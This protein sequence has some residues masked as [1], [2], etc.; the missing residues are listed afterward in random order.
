MG[1]KARIPHPSIIGVAAPEEV[2]AMLNTF[3]DINTLV[4][5][6]KKRVEETP[7]LIKKA[8]GLTNKRITKPNKGYVEA[9]DIPKKGSMHQVKDVPY[10]ER[11]AQFPF[12][13]QDMALM[14][15][16]EDM[17]TKNYNR[18]RE[19]KKGEKIKWAGIYAENLRTQAAASLA[20]G[21]ATI[22]HAHLR[23]LAQATSN[24]EHATQK[25]RRTKNEV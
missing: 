19:A 13:L 9:K 11:R 22:L 2:E 8:L 12:Y 24:D 14:A 17:S 3:V 6:G 7:P 4:L 16:T 10:P 15:K 21:G 25:E 20:K 18:L 1:C 5:L 23:V